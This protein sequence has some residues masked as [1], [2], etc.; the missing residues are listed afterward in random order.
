MVRL[1]RDADG[2]TVEVS[3][4]PVMPHGEFIIWGG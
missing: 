1:G 3:I 4:L 2:T